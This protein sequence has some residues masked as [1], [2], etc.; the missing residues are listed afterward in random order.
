MVPKRHE[1]IWRPPISSKPAKGQITLPVAR[2]R[3]RGPGGAGRVARAGYGSAV[4]PPST[5]SSIPVM[6]EALS[7]NKNKQALA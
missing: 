6:K 4:M 1:Q 5:I 7:D 2:A 3:W